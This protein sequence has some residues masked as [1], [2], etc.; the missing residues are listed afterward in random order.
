VTRNPVI[1]AAVNLLAGFGIVFGPGTL[2]AQDKAPKTVSICQLTS[3][4][5]KFLANPVTLRIRVNAGRH[6][7][8]ISDRA[9]P[10]QSLLLVDAQ[11]AV[12]TNILSHFHEFLADHRRSSKPIFATLAGRLV[13]GPE[14]GF[15]LKRDYDFELESVSEISEGNQSKHP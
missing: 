12:K 6:A 9:C 11:G 15:V 4:P 8:S 10:K 2:H 5:K 7:T 3:Q 1:Y 14:R 13:I